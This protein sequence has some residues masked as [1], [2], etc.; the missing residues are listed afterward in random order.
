MPELS[1]HACFRCRKVF[2]KPHWYKTKQTPVPPEYPCPEC[3]EPLLA[4]GYKFRAPRRDDVKN[5]N[6]IKQAID[7]GTQWEVPTNRKEKRD[8]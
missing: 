7:S 6:R 2:K 1:A 8:A 3:G 5:W 4:M